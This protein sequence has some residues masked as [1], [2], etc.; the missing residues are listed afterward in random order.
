MSLDPF[1]IR[2]IV[3]VGLWVI[4]EALFGLIVTDGNVKRIFDLILI[5]IIVLFILFGSVFF[6]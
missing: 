2:L 3:G 6:H 5:I 1:V 4:L